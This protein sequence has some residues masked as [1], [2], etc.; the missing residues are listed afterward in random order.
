MI[1]KR[2]GY[3]SAILTIALILYII[4]IDFDKTTLILSILSLFVTI[5]ALWNKKE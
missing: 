2:I 1:I 3:I 4:F 5:L